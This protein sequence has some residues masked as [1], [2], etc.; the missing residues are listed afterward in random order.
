[1]KYFLPAVLQK[2]NNWAVFGLISKIRSE[3]PDEKIHIISSCVE[4]SSI[5]KSLEAAQK[6]NVE[7]DF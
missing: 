1:M 4:H 3:N 5:M 6:L 7:V 2:T